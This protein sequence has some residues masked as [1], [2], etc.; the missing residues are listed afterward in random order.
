MNDIY[1]LAED[2]VR[3]N[4]KIDRLTGVNFGPDVSYE[5]QRHE[6]TLQTL[7]AKITLT[8]QKEYIDLLLKTETLFA[9]VQQKARLL[10]QHRMEALIAKNEV[11]MNE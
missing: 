9:M 2:L 8:T 6:K 1:T 4:E 5:L 10:I 11:A 3:L 7:N